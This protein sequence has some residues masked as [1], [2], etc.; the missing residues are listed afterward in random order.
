MDSKQFQEWQEHPTTKE[1]MEFLRQYRLS[2]MEAWAEG[3]YSCPTTEAT[4]MKQAEVL[5]KVQ[6]YQ[7]L[8]SLEF[9]FIR[10]FYSKETSDAEANEGNG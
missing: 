5:A 8:A 10:Q 7:D 6:C 4:A 9:E 3:A 2:L 1:V